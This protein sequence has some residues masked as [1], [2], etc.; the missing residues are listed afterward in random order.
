MFGRF[1]GWVFGLATAAAAAA[2]F[3]TAGRSI[4]E[5]WYQINANSLV[6]L[7]SLIEKRLDPNP[8]D[9]TLYF[10]YVLPVLNLSLWL[11]VAVLCAVLAIVCFAVGARARK[12]RLFAR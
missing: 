8:E 3:A 2:H 7:Q 10:D 12:R 5:I 1:L 9:P 4:A 6:G 11:V